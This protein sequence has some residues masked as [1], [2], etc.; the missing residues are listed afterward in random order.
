MR[1]DARAALS[2]LRE[3]AFVE[4][5]SHGDRLLEGAFDHLVRACGVDPVEAK[6]RVKLGEGAPREGTLLERVGLREAGRDAP[7][8]DLLDRL[9]I[10]RDEYQSEESAMTTTTE[11]YL[12]IVPLSQFVPVRSM[13]EF[14]GRL[15]YDGKRPGVAERFRGDHQLLDGLDKALR[16]RRGR[17]GAVVRNGYVLADEPGYLPCVGDLPESV[18]RDCVDEVARERF[19]QWQLKGNDDEPIL[20]RLDAHFAPLQQ[21][22]ATRRREQVELAERRAQ[23]RRDAAEREA[24]ACAEAGRALAAQHEA[25]YQQRVGA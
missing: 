18:V 10:D 6:E 21:T 13:R 5:D 19:G 16:H 9:G 4:D 11:N 3:A 24:R 1:Q 15:G 22:W 14:V 8:G 25:E 17:V 23:A 12:E 7:T 20:D 2:M